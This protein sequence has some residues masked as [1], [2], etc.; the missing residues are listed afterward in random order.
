M[1]FVCIPNIPCLHSQYSMCLR[2]VCIGSVEQAFPV[3]LL[4]LLCTIQN[5]LGKEEMVGRVGVEW[6]EGTDDIG[7]SISLYCQL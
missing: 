4:N 7:V 3:Y 1:K 6:G 5:A 2:T